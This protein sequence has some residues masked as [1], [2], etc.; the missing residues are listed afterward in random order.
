LQVIIPYLTYPGN[1]EEAIALYTSVLGGKATYLSR[2]TKETGGCALAGKVMHAQVSFGHGAICCGDQDG[3]VNHGDA[4]RLLVHCK[5]A[6]EARRI[7]DAFAAGGKVI[8]PLTPHPPPD[9]AGMGA[10]VQDRFGYVWILT[11]PGV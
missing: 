1:C 11:V 4:M 6:A 9:D 7:M 8:E 10:L 2:W 5:G 3:P